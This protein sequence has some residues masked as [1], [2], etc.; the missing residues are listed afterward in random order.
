MKE[1]KSMLFFKTS[2]QNIQVGF[3]MVELLKCEVNTDLSEYLLIKPLTL[4]IDNITPPIKA[5]NKKCTVDNTKQ[6]QRYI[7]DIFN[8]KQFKAIFDN[9]NKNLLI[10][11]ILD[12]KNNLNF[13]LCTFIQKLERL[14]LSL[15][16]VE[17]VMEYRTISQD[18]QIHFKHL[19]CMRYNNKYL[20]L[21]LE[22]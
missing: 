14:P 10:M 12:H 22:W 11:Y 16:S 9:P 1:L 4:N 3:I 13:T 21:W 15:N 8:K 19:F 2:K 5:C 6:L 7:R 20:Q 17:F 18:T